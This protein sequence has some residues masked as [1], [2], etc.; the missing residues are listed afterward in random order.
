MQTDKEFI[1]SGIRMIVM[2]EVLL[3]EINEREANQYFT[4][5]LKISCRNFKS[6]M[7]KKILNM[8]KAMNFNE[9]ATLVFHQKVKQLKEL[10]TEANKTIEL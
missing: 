10:Y 9:D 2:M 3:D 7:E 5:F 8:Y 1:D 4:P 6:E